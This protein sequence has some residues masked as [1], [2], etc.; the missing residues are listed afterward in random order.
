MLRSFLLDG[1]SFEHT[2]MRQR[3]GGVG[4]DFGMMQFKDHEQTDAQSH[5]R[6]EG[7]DQQVRHLVYFFK[8]H[9]Y[10]VVDVVNSS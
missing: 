2:E 6:D 7:C 8:K 1:D 3:W 10:F 5:R 9:T 4:S